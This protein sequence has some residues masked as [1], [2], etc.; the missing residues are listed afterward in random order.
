MARSSFSKLAHNPK[1]EPEAAPTITAAPQIEAG[2]AEPMLPMKAPKVQRS[3]QGKKAMTFY[4][5]VE[6][7]RAL[8]VLAA[9]NDRLIEDMAREAFNDLLRKF[10]KHPQ[11]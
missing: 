6:M 7:A 8:K 5:S 3:R 4:V 2:E 1:P 10:E 9:E 11:P